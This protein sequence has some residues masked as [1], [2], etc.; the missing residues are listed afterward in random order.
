MRW[1]AT[2][3]AVS[4]ERIK[5]LAEIR[6]RT[7]EGERTVTLVALSARGALVLS[8]RAIGVAGECV[9][10]ELPAVGGKTVTVAAGV[11]KVH[12][13]PEGMV[14]KVEFMIVEASIRKAV[15]D[16]LALLLAGDGG[17]TRRSPRVKYGVPVLYGELGQ[18]RAKLIEISLNGLAMRAAVGL[19]GGTPLRVELPDALVLQGTV[20]N[21]RPSESVAGT[22]EIGMVFDQLPQSTLIAL[23][24]LLSDLVR[25]QR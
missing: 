6:L 7:T 8:Q 21:A 20:V 11:D 14:S 15:D 4:T 13:V 24:T 16:L 5:V 23:R 10:L 18:H 2:D 9:D 17:G 19:A 3:P 25:S 12:K 1:P 22:F